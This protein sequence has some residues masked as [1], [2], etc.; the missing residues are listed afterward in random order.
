M[1]KNTLKTLTIPR[2]SDFH[3]H[4]RSPAQVGEELFRMIVTFNCAHYRYV[5]VEPNTFLNPQR[6]KHHIE[7]ARD[8]DA[9][10]KLVLT[11][12]QGNA[13]CSPLFLIKLTPRTTPQMIT[14]AASTGCVGVKLY[15]E[16]VTVGSEHGGITNFM[17][18]QI[19]ACIK[20]LE[21]LDMV[22]QIHPEMPRT[23]CLYRE[24]LF[25]KIIAGY[26][27]LFPGLRIFIE[28]ITDRRTLDLISEL[29]CDQGASIFGTITG[30]H[31]EIT[32]DN[33]LGQVDNHC[34][35]CAKEP[36]DRTALIEAATSGACH[37][38]SITD[39]APH[40]YATKH[41]AECACAGVFNP[42]EIA[43][44]R[45]VTLFEKSNALDNLPRFTSANGLLAYKK[46]QSIDDTITLVK[47]TWEVPRWYSTGKGDTVTPF[48]SRKK[49]TWAIK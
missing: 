24:Y 38:I 5:V 4:L 9:Y 25:H 48:M 39:S 13:S 23:F 12:L 19:C 22:L 31:L 1:K 10:R 14:D 7:N 36:D 37:I 29:R 11:A 3:S 28:H 41:L 49:M 21:E 6:P 42:A 45:L 43:I 27:K 18:D 35:P 16:G 17:S 33:V 15:P 46:K 32:L 20:R 47:K 44:P 30:H 2:P 40:E 26:A 34:W 8:L